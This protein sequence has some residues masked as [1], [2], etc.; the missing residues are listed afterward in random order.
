MKRNIQLLVIILFGSPC[1]ISKDN[2]V[3]GEIITQPQ[4]KQHNYSLLGA[5]ATKLLPT[6]GLTIP[7]KVSLY[8][9][10]LFQFFII[11]WYKT[12][13]IVLVF[14]YDVRLFPI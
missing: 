7:F 2:F 5:F 8:V 12:F 6:L 10:N 11:L 1:I 4:S 3:I 9:Y 13:F 14:I